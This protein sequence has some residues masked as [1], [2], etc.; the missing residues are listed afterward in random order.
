[1]R[2][3]GREKCHRLLDIGYGG[4]VFLPE[5]SGICD[6]LYGVDIHNNM[7]KVGQMLIKENVRAKLSYGDA[8]N[9]PF[10]NGYFDRVVCISVLEFVKD[11]DKAFSEMARV[12][13]DGGDAVIGFPVVSF[14]T[15]IAF[16]MIGI[17]SRKAHPV[18]QDDIL[19]SARKY[20]DVD[21]LRTFPANL[22]LKLSLFAHCRLKKKN[23]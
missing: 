20:F 6:E 10:E 9:L 11:L 19:S 21:T 22:P 8:M 1:M 12:L 5:L 7:D 15:D 2:L 17:N 13:K 14:L 4:G 3:L 23:G 16:L 18:D